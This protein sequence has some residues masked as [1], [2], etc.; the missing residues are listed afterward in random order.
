ML[1]LVFDIIKLWYCIFLIFYILFKLFIYLCIR[2][3]CYFIFK[4]I[5]FKF[6]IRFR[7]K[8]LFFI[9]KYESRNSN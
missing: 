8:K 6:K 2:W 4:K 3:N 1:Y 5:I 7:K 9:K